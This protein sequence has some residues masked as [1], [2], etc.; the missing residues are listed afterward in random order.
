[1]EEEVYRDPSQLIVI[2]AA[3]YLTEYKK[4]KKRKYW[5]MK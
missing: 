4:K 5:I 2:T 1:M 3:L